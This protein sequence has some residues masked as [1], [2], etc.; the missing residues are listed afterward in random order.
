MPKHIFA[1]RGPLENFRRIYSNA[2]MPLHRKQIILRSVL[3]AFARVAC[4][5][6]LD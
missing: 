6:P 1:W 3:R 4:W 2:A 5:F